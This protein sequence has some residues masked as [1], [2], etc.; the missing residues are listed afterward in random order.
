MTISTKN[1]PIYV[2]FL[3]QSF[4]FKHTPVVSWIFTLGSR[5][6]QK[7]TRPE[8][9]H[10]GSSG[11]NGSPENRASEYPVFGGGATGAVVHIAA[12]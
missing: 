11:G 4:F 6:K 10:L 3:C 5:K 1:R 12:N 7:M 2:T 9:S 8:L